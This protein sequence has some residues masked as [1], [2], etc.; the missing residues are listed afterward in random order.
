MTAHINPA[1][2][3]LACI[4]GVFAWCAFA[5]ASTCDRMETIRR[6]LEGV[7]IEGGWLF[8]VVAPDPCQHTTGKGGEGDRVGR[9]SH[10]G[11][12]Q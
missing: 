3:I 10:F 11:T 2:A 6:D 7:E 9:V 4:V 5:V 12:E 8:D 1:L